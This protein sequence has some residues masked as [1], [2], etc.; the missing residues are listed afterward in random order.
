[1]SNLRT[2]LEEYAQFCASGGIRGLN[3][4]QAEQKIKGLMLGEKEIAELA[5]NFSVPHSSGI[6]IGIDNRVCKPLSTAI[7]SAMVRKMEGK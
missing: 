1:M 4:D 2:I 3:Q 7:Y 5:K 6:G